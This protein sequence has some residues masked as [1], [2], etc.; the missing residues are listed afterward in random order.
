MK[1][2]RIPWLRDATL[3]VTAGSPIPPCK[4]VTSTGCDELSKCLIPVIGDI[5]DS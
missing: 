1:V 5:D 2:D 4:K 3:I